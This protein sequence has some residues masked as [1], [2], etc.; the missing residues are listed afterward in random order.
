MNPFQG[1]SFGDAILA[2]ILL[3]LLGGVIGL[4]SVV[5][6]EI[7]GIHISP[8]GGIIITGSG[9]AILLLLWIKRR[10]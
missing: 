2:A 5:L 10:D 4:L 8:A 6:L 7:V 1:G 3:V 9:I